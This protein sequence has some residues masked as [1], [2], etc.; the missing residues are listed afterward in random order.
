MIPV[1]F[2]CDVTLAEAEKERL[3]ANHDKKQSGQ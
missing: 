3:K 2:I 1:E